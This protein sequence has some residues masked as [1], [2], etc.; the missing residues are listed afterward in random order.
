M[1]NLPSLSTE[2]L[3]L[4][5]S[6]S[7][8]IQTAALLSRISQRFRAVWLENSDQII[9]NI[10]EPR[11]LAYK[12]AAELAILEETWSDNSHQV[13][14]IPIRLCLHRLLHNADLASSATA[15]W[16]AYQARVR[17]YQGYRPPKTTYTSIAASYYL[18]RGLLLARQRPES[19]AL[20]LPAL[21]KKIVNSSTDAIVT[22]IDFNCF[23]TGSSA[24][25]KEQLR[26]DILKPE[27]EWS[28]SDFHADSYGDLIIYDSW[29][30]VGDVLD[31]AMF[32]RTCVNNNNLEGLIFDIP[33]LR[34][35]EHIKEYGWADGRS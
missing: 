23:L 14:Q 1:A 35:P 15:G 11:I 20:L 28:E 8:T 2:L 9:A 22:P 18:A 12:D 29:E 26:H 25:R 5:Y 10:L 33:E 30:W 24:S 31:T 4:T 32:D 21:V 6:S 17:S 3:V 16:D 7:P 27:E 34:S 13:D 19:R